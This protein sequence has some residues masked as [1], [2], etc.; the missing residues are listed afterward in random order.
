M[1][2]YASMEGQLILERVEE[3]HEEEKLKN[4]AKEIRK[5]KKLRQQKLFFCESNVFEKSVCGAKGYRQCTQCRDVM[6]HT[7]TKKK[8]REETMLK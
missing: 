2:I 3:L 5:I 6:K 7:R 1:Q 8:F 4:V